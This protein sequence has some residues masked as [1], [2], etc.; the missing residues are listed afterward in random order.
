MRPQVGDFEEVL[1]GGDG[2]DFP[3]IL[4]KGESEEGNEGL[5]LRHRKPPVESHL[6]AVVWLRESLFG[7]H[8]ES[9]IEL[10]FRFEEVVDAAHL[11]R[12]EAQEEKGGPNR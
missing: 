5:T 7:G 8:E 4:E 1:D 6:L 9:L 10:D 11:T 2:L 3:D 12:E